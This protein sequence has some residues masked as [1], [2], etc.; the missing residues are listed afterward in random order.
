MTML[1][2]ILAVALFAAAVLPSHAEEAYEETERRLKTIGIE[3]PLRL[4]IHDAI[5]RGVA[6][7]RAEQH[8]NGSVYQDPG[9]TALAGL[10]L[11]HAGIP[12]GREAGRKALDW[13]AAHAGKRTGDQVY[14]AGIAAML[15]AAEGEPKRFAHH[16]H[17]RLSKGPRRGLGYWGYSTRGGTGPPNL[18]TAQFACLGLW[19][20]ERLGAETATQAWETHLE[21]LLAAQSE[22]GSWSYYPLGLEQFRTF[23][24]YPTGTFM[25]L[26]N[27]A[28]ARAALDEEL[29]KDPERRAQV[30]IAL[31]AGKAALRRHLHWTLAAPGM[32]NALGT[33]PYYRLY[34]LEKACIFLDLEDVGGIPWY[35]SGALA[36]LE[37]QRD[38]G[39]WTTAGAGFR[40]GRVA[41]GRAMH[42]VQTSFALLFLL[43]ASSVY[44]PVTPT[45]VDPPPVITPGPAPV[46]AAPT[47][48]DVA[49]PLPLAVKALDGLERTL[50]QRRIRDPD[51][52]LEALRFIE[53][54]YPT[55][56][57]DGVARSGAHDLW[58]RR[59]EDLLVRAAAR[60]L[61]AK[62]EDRVLRQ[63]L[64]LR[65]LD[66]LGKTSPRVFEALR[67]L[68]ERAQ[69]GADFRGT[70]PMAYR[71]ALLDA[72]RRVEAPELRTWLL[73]TV[74][75]P[76]PGAWIG[77]STALTCLGGLEGLT[78][79][80]RYETAK[81]IVARLGPL[82]RRSGSAP[83]TRDLHMDLW[84][85]LVRLMGPE[86]A[87]PG[88]VSA[89]DPSHGAD[90]ARALWHAH[91]SPND[92]VWRD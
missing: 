88:Q 53:R 69:A 66:V 63:A 89:F 12:P 85:V 60:G 62:A 78:G 6:A 74:L 65:A 26:A 10:A 64:S 54:T 75:D 57:P 50:G 77:T 43:R 71:G 87:A 31:A 49:L 5:R 32:G 30:E 38:D 28:L 90:Q 20:G 41:N 34:A 61:G 39:S 9:H 55:Y 91:R 13:L 58:C 11:L 52:A 46:D 83:P 35:R 44:H 17:E 45:S 82:L 37:R 14:A 19:S 59:A 73:E 76:D 22:Y 86:V 27:L 80:E 51:P 3:E 33:F 24:G 2:P 67:T 36:I 16:L 81:Q 72:L 21:A 25:G 7:L 84:V 8:A 4:R 79:R 70:F 42:A 68:A 47:R 40:T 18:S 29:A 15:V 56:R 48:R 1:R 92:P 23:Q